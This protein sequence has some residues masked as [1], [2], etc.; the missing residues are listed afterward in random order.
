MKI[1]H[2]PYLFLSSCLFLAIT[3]SNTN[4]HNSSAMANETLKTIN[5]P[6][7]HALYATYDDSLLK[8]LKNRYTH[9]KFTAQPIDENF[10]SS[11]LWTAYGINR[12]DG[13]RTIPT[14]RNSQDM[15]I[16]LVN[17]E[18]FWLY[19]PENHSLEQKI[20]GDN[21]KFLGSN[22]SKS[23]PLTLIYVQDMNKAS[24]EH[25]GY[26][27]A[28]SM[29]QGVALFCAM[30]N[31]GNVVIGSLPSDFNKNLQ[32]PETQRLIVSQSVGIKN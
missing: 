3:F 18:G 15:L 10:L 5:L 19:H 32:L 22:I 30:A 21:R 31:L 20:S 23:A 16:Y 28:G 7:P 27:H 17:E 26:L 12:D 2:L 24:S 29:Y 6:D 25:Y 1:Q 4:L 14:A 11:L 8:A 13:K 9:R